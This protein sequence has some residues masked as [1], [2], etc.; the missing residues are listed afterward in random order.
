MRLYS[1]NVN[2]GLGKWWCSYLQ[3]YFNT[4]GKLLTE[5]NA[6]VVH[7]TSVDT[8]RFD[9]NAG[10]LQDQGDG[11]TYRRPTTSLLTGYIRD[12][13]TLTFSPAFATAPV[14]LFGGGGYTFEDTGLVEAN[15]LVQ[16]YSADNLLVTGF[17]ANLKLQEL[18]GT[19][20]Q[21]VLTTSTSVTYTWEVDK[22]AAAEA[23]DNK[24]ILQY[25]VTVF[26]VILNDYAWAYMSL[27][28]NTGSGWTFSRTVSKTHWGLGSTAYLNQTEN[29]TITGMGAGSDF[30]IDFS[31]DSGSST[32]NGDSVTYYTA[33]AGTAISATPVGAPDIPRSEERRVGK[34]CRSRWSPYH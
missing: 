18:A 34:E 8:V 4:E 22:P 23:W 33:T 1:P 31:A 29:L 20:T 16:K 9:L 25:D 24:Y 6:I 30:A 27:Y 26:G 14:V 10:N 15:G 19:P 2:G 7:K 5:D 17:D 11:T 21:V 32:F 12:G 28:Y 13:E 3:Y